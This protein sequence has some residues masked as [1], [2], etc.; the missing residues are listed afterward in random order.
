MRLGLIDHDRGIQFLPLRTPLMWSGAE[1]RRGCAHRE[2]K[3]VECRF[4]DVYYSKAQ[5]EGKA[6]AMM[7]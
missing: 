5:A 3:D 6:D 4:F 7:L 1:D 2:V